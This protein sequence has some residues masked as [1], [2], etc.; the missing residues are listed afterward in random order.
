MSYIIM[1]Y[2]FSIIHRSIKHSHSTIDV[3]NY[4]KLGCSKQTLSMLTLCDKVL[5]YHLKRCY[6]CISQVVQ[7]GKHAP[8]GNGGITIV[9]NNIEGDQRRGSSNQTEANPGLKSGTV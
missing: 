5:Y 2:F 9:S 6:S 8:T 7:E 3:L 1:I 4:N